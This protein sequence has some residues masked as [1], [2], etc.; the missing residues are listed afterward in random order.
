[1]MILV[2]GF[3]LLRNKCCDDVG[4]LLDNSFG[5]G[6]VH[7]SRRA[8]MILRINKSHLTDRGIVNIVWSFRHAMARSLIPTSIHSVSSSFAAPLCK[9]YES[10]T[11]F[12]HQVCV[13]KCSFIHRLWCIPAKIFCYAAVLSKD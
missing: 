3:C 9:E 8:D 13:P 10:F 4:F 2:Y 11:M 1:M 6:L 5:E 12:S 7:T